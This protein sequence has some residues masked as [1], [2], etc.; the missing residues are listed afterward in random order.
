VTIRAADQHTIAGYTPYEGIRVQGQVRTVL[1]RGHMLIE[2]GTLHGEPGR[3]L[4]LRGAP[5][6]PLTRC[7]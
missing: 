4:F 6:V 1:S 5:F 3:G 2:D 7:K